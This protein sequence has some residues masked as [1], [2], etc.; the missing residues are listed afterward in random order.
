MTIPVLA[1]LFVGNFDHYRNV[2]VL[3]D[4]PRPSFPARDLI[5][6]DGLE[7][8]LETYCRF[9]PGSDRR[10]LVS[11]WSRTYFVKLTVPTVAA[12][13]VLGRQLP[14]ELETLEVI[15]GDDGLVEAFRL[16]HDGT[17]F[18]AAPDGPFER[19][20]S[21]ITDNFEPLIEGWNGQ[22][23]I[24]R[25]VLWNNAAN[26]FEWLI[27]AMA[28]MGLPEAMLADGR[29]LIDRER[30]PDGRR[31]PMWSPVRYVEREDGPS[32]LR[33]RRHCC[34][35]YR[36]PDLALCSNCPHID[37]PPKGARLPEQEG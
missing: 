33:Q 32:P 22:V 30:Q 12:N 25:N 16:P 11:Q 29:E 17:P 2:L 23:K 26:Y 37:R 19:F 13:L 31:N 6:T 36:L 27:G 9:Q 18:S 34:I 14:V 8:L 35:R 15:L 20:R 28:G 7:R 3:A 4:D 24:S 5:T 1:P 21:L 10:A